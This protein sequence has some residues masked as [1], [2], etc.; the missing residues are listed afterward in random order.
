[1][2]A[3]MRGVPTREAIGE[4]VH[5]CYS[6]IRLFPS[7]FLSLQYSKMEDHLVWLSVSRSNA[8]VVKRFGRLLTSRSR[9]LMW[10]IEVSMERR[11][12][13]KGGGNVRSPRKPADQRHRPPSRRRIVIEPTSREFPFP[14][15]LQTAVVWSRPDAVDRASGA[16]CQ[17]SRSSAPSHHNPDIA[18]KHR[19]VLADEPFVS[20]I[21]D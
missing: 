10:V 8:Q 1:M 18:V 11:R 20:L 7:I 2:A 6:G 9:E 19:H 15:L 21:L 17:M 12:N 3:K 4:D 14:P 5:Y 16:L 13:E